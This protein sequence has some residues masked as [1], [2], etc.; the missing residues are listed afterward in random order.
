MINVT[1]PAIQAF[2]DHFKD[3]DTQP[4]RIHLVD[5]GCS[6]MRLSLALDEKRDEDLAVEQE[7]FQF[8]VNSELAEA[9]GELSIDMTEYGFMVNSEKNV[10]GGGCASGSCGSSGGCSSSGCGC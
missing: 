9:T 5:G 3:K 6:G 1:P 10:G 8:V 4:I 7:G 2:S